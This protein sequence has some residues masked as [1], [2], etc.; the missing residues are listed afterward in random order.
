M[1]QASEFEKLMSRVAAGSEDAM[2][3]LAETYTPYIIRTVRH[4]LSPK[5]RQKLDSQD[6]AQTLWTALLLRREDLIRLK[7][8][9]ELIRYLAGATRIKICE[10]ARRYRAQ[11]CDINREERLENYSSHGRHKTSNIQRLHSRDSS[12]STIVSI[13]DHW[14]HVLSHASE[15]DQQ[16]VRMRYEGETFETIGEKLQINEQTARRAMHR[17]LEQF[18][19]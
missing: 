14:S 1:G 18:T 5:L 8:P 6:F 4:T 2:W 3:E 19:S 9:E 16:I 15:R 10:K 11:K 13:R 12:P 7:T 17:I